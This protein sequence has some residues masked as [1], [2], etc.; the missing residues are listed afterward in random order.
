MK[1]GSFNS[2]ASTY[3]TIHIPSSPFQ[4]DDG[5]DE[6]DLP[7]EL[8]SLEKKLQRLNETIDSA[9]QEMLT[10]YHRCLLLQRHANFLGSLG[11]VIP[12]ELDLSSIVT[13][14]ESTSLCGSTHNPVPSPVLPFVF[15]K[16]VALGMFS[17]VCEMSAERGVGEYRNAGNVFVGDWRNISE[18]GEDLSMKVVLKFF[19]L[20][21]GSSASSE[22]S[23]LS[24]SQYQ[25]LMRSALSPRLIGQC[26]FIVP[27]LCSFLDVHAKDSDKYG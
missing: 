26:P 24:V 20:P 4:F 14:Q 9:R 17:D 19:H 6:A 7:S 5:D 10:R 25:V 1:H 21:A 12:S 27:L 8:D 11:F 13:A 15:T 22:L 3:D 23:P 16:G 18:D 2:I